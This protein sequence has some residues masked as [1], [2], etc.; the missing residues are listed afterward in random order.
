MNRI[1]QGKVTNFEIP[2]PGDKEN[3]WQPLHDWQSA[4]WQHHELFH[5]AVNSV[6]EMRK[7]LN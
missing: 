1:Y 5:D 4:L 3:P 7:Q 2:K 6:F